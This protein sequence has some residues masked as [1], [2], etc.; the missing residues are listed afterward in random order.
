MQGPTSTTCCVSFYI[1]LAIVAP[2]VSSLMHFDHHQLGRLMLGVVA[3]GFC[4]ALFYALWS[5]ELRLQGRPP[6]TRKNDP[7]AFW[8]ATTI[9]TIVMGIFVIMAIALV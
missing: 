3:T 2:W 8:M 7:I 1:A 5:G 4:C 9:A 6:F